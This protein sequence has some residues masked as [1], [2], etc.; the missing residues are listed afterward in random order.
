[1]ERGPWKTLGS[2]V[3]YENAWIRLRHDRVI[4]PGGGEGI[5]GVVETAPAI[6][7]VALTGDLRV[8]LVGQYRYPLEQYSWEIPEGGGREGETLAEAARRELR[9]ETGLTARRWT[10]LGTAATSNCVTDEIAHFFLAE[11]LTEG[12]P[13]PD[14]TEALEV[15]VVPFAEAHEMVRRGEIQD[16]MSII[17]LYRARDL[18]EERE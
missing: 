2:E 5:Y 4:T 7:V 14:E 6:G 18:L 1:M 10:S 11:D 15:K 12:D 13:T 9:E 16:A 8:Y 3:V 17:A